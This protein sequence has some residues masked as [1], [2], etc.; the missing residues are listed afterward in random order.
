MVPLLNRD[1]GRITAIRDAF[2]RILKRHNEDDTVLKL[3][4]FAA[5][6]LL[7]AHQDQA[8]A[9]RAELLR[10]AL[11]AAPGAEA[12]AG[13]RLPAL[14]VIVGTDQQDEAGMRLRVRRAGPDS[15]VSR[16]RSAKV[17]THDVCLHFGQERVKI[18]TELEA[19]ANK[20]AQT[21]AGSLI[22][23]MDILGGII[24]R[25]LDGS[26]GVEWWFVEFLIGDAI[27]TNQAAAKLMW[28][29]A[30][31]SPPAGDRAEFFLICVVCGTHQA[32]LTARHLTEGG[33][34]LLGS[35]NQEAAAGA[36]A[37]FE[38]ARAAAGAKTVPH[39]T[40]CGTAVRFFKYL[41]GDYYEE[42][43]SSLTQWVGRTLKMLGKDEARTPHTQTHGFIQ[44]LF[45]FG[46]ESFWHVKS[47]ARFQ[48]F[49]MF[50]VGGWVMRGQRCRG[51]AG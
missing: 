48:T 13:A 14:G 21:L 43:L 36:G 10:K 31:R 46:I 28:S 22:R 23:V 18:F 25:A 50:G 3:Q 27:P 26:V 35:L 20:K 17:Q 30:C 44:K 37:D 9:M 34:A 42:F 38:A 5:R 33:G 2:V 6:T 7:A 32:N 11:F 49:F 41:I 47:K 24:G 51:S 16:S 19:L 12:A 40:F 4:A 1:V 45:A 39:R 15:A 8:A 29:K